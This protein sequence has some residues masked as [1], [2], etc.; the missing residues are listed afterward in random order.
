MPGDT[1]TAISGARLRSL[2]SAVRQLVPAPAANVVRPPASG[3]PY[4]ASMYTPRDF[5]ETRLDVIHEAIRS[6]PFATL[7]T[8]GADGL[9]ATHLPVI[10]DDAASP[11]GTLRAHVARANRQWHDFDGEVL[12]IFSG[13]HAY[14]S[15]SWYGDTQPSVPTWNYLAVHAYGAAAHHR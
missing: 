15:P 9:V 7:V 12:V 11:N 10:L 3:T 4:P 6:N 13:P 5:A 8:A 14:I 2:S 1:G